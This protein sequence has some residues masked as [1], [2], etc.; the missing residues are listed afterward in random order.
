[1]PPFVFSPRANVIAR[2]VVCA[3]PLLVGLLGLVAWA[4]QQ[5]PYLTDQGVA[6]DQPVPFSHQHHVGGLGIDCRFC[7]AAVAES[8]TAG[9]PATKVCMS[10][11][12]QVWTNAP[13]LEPVRESWR[14]GTPIAW[15]RVHR[16]PDYV[17]FDHGAHVTHGIGC[18]SCHG[19]IDQM[20]LVAQAA[21][22]TM[23]WCL[24]CHRNPEAH[25]RPREAV[26]DLTYVAPPD[27]D[28]LGRELVERYAIRSSQA[29]TDCGTCH[30]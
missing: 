29:L 23:S 18:A 20:P 10:C 22:L 6:I 13:V 25:V 5:S 11:H 26:F 21:P 8:A 30:R 1:M 19:R 16:L 27:Q 28:R 17:Y 9:M 15:N 2:L 4:V 14:E 24:D 3:V 7:H 12:S